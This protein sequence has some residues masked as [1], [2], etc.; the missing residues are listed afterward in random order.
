MNRPTRNQRVIVSLFIA[1]V[2]GLLQYFRAAEHGGRSD[3]APVWHAARLMLRGQ[4]PYDLIGPGNVVESAWPM[5]YP[6]TTFVVAIPFSIIP[7]FHL[8]SSVFVFVSA[9][10]LAWGITRDGWHML[11]IFPSIAF[12]T[13]ATLAQWS[14]LMTALVYLP[15]LGFLA[16][17]KPQAAI[18][19][20]GSSTSPRILWFAI[21]G[22][23]AIV[24]LSFVFMPSWPVDWLNLLGTTE[25]FVPPLFRFAGPVILLVLLRWRRPE[26]WLVFLSACMPQT[27]PAYN[28]LVLMTVAR[29]YHEA[30]FLSLVSSISW[31]GFALW[32]DGMTF[33]QERIWMSTVLNMSSFLPATLLIL[34]RPNEGQGPF[35]IEWILR[36]FRVRSPARTS[37]IGG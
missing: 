11:P 19:I 10:L 29:T 27:W 24:A 8:A 30:S 21:G 6:A 17:G 18:P 7:T 25:N 4:N 28:G 34:R 36:K 3:F 16:A 1:T 12:L 32:V 26:S 31:V 23:L 13:C 2:S 22:G 37:E 5:F 35:W 33:E 14:I 15:V 9:L 20:I